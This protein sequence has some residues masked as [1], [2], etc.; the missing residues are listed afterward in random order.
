MS[1]LQ[2][3][4]HYSIKQWIRA[5]ST[6][7]FYPLLIISYNQSDHNNNHPELVNSKTKALST[8]STSLPNINSI[9]SSRKCSNNILPSGSLS[10]LISMISELPFCSFGCTSDIGF[11]H[12]MVYLSPF[13][14]SVMRVS[15][16]SVSYCIILFH[17]SYVKPSI[18]SPFTFQ[19]FF[20][21]TLH[22][23]LT[24]KSLNH[25]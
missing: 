8:S 6:F 5:L 1:L 19:H 22:L 23:L 2:K 10:V 17:L 16:T 24:A 3:S 12:A 13:I 7:I 20:A 15:L 4:N 9:S 25:N 21:L 18:S 11:M 14:I